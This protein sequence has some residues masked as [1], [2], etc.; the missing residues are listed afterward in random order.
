[1]VVYTVICEDIALFDHKQLLICNER[2]LS[3]Q[4]FTELR[5]NI[6]KNFNFS[7]FTTLPTWINRVWG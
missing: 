6:T 7:N 1:M 2:S 5:I 3:L 4:G